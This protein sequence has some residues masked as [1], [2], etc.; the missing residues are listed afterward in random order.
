MIFC[1][2]PHGRPSHV[3]F[4]VNVE[5]FARAESDRTFAAFAEDAGGV[6]RLEHRTPATATSRRR[7]VCG[8]AVPGRRPEP[9]TDP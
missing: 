5:D 1:P 7:A 4:R 2:P 8:R 3:P 6:N 9:T